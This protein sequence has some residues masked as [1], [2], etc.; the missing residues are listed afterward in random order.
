[1]KI[2]IAIPVYGQANFLQSALESIRVRNN[3]VNLAIMDATPDDSV[4]EVLN[5]Y[6][7]L[8]AYH[9]H[10]PDQGQ[11]AAIQEGWDNTDGEIIAWLCADDYYFPYTLDLIRQVF[12]DHPDVDVVYGD[13]VFVDE[14]EKFIGYFPA[15]KKSINAITRECC[16]S[17]PSCFVRRTAFEKIG[18]KLNDGLHYTMDWDLWIRLYKSGAKFYY[19][20]KP[21]SVVRMYPGTKTSSRSWQRFYEIGQHLFN[22]NNPFSAIRSLLG[23][24]YQDLLSNQTNGFDRLMLNLLNCYRSLK[25]IKPHPSSENDMN[26]GFY[27]N[28]HLVGSEVEVYLPWYKKEKPS[29]VV[30][31]CDLAETPLAYLNGSPLK[32]TEACYEISDFDTSTYL[33]ELKLVSETQQNWHLYGVSF[34]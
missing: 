8:F 10:G 1:M 17:Q 7:G 12:I 6:S 29:R 34:I 15:I 4:Q 26:Y 23:F 28:N 16:I 11:T 19:L 27:K 24:Y 31:D 18:G 5:G 20:N 3:Y 13:S 21:L 25:T 30:V 2:S 22:N 14:C 9:R 33:L 32:F